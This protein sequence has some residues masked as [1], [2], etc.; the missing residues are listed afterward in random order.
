MALTWTFDITDVNVPK[1][2]VKIAA[3]ASDDVTTPPTTTSVGILNADI[4]TP[5]LKIAALDMIWTNYLQKRAAASA[6]ATLL[7]D[8]EVAAKTNL[9]KREVPEE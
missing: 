1:R 2:I 8:M 5:A 6:V 9:E 7:G 4:S 3:I